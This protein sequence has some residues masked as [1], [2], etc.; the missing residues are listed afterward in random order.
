MT[1]KYAPISFVLLFF[2]LTVEVVGQC[3]SNLVPNPSF[4]D[5]TGC[6]SGTSLGAPFNFDVFDN[7]ANW[8]SP[9]GGTSDAMSTCNGKV[10][11]YFFYGGDNQVTHFYQNPVHGDGIAAIYINAPTLQ[12]AEYLQVELTGPLT[13]GVTYQLEFYASLAETSLIG[14]QIGG[15][16]TN[17]A[18]EDYSTGGVLSATPQVTSGIITDK[19]NWTLVSGSFT[20]T[21][22]ERFLTLGSFTGNAGWTDLGVVTS[23]DTYAAYMLIDQV[24]IFQFNDPIPIAGANQ[25]FC[26]GGSV[27]LDA[28]LSN[29]ISYSWTPSTGLN[30]PNIANPIA[31][32]ASTTTYTVSVDYGGGCIKQDQVTLTQVNCDC[33][34]LNYTDSVIDADC[35]GGLGLLRLAGTDPSPNTSL[36]IEW[37]DAVTGQIVDPNNSSRIQPALA[38]TYNAFIRDEYTGCTQTING[39]VVGEPPLYEVN[40]LN[41][42]PASCAGN[43]GSVEVSVTGGTPMSVNSVQYRI[44]IGSGNYISM[45]SNTITLSNLTP[46]TYL[47]EVL[48]DNNCILN[49]T[50]TITTNCT[51]CSAT[52]EAGPDINLCRGDF[53]TIPVTVS[54]GTPVSVSW[55]PTYALSDPTVLN[56]TFGVNINFGPT[57]YTVTVDFGGGCVYSDYLVI[58][59]KA[60]FCSVSCTDVV[61]AGLDQTINAGDTANL[62]AASSGGSPTYT[63]TASPADPSLAGQENQQSPTVSPTQTTTYMVTADFGGGC[64]ETDDVIITVN[65][66]CTE[67]VDAGTDETINLGNSATITATPSGGTPSYTWTASPADPSLSGQENTQNPTVSPTQTTTYTVTADFG[68]GC[69]DT[70]DVVVT[71]NTPPIFTCLP[72]QTIVSNRSTENW[73]FGNNAGLNFSTS[74][75][76]IVTDGNINVR[77]G[78]TTISDSNGNLLFYTSANSVMNSNHLVMTNGAGISAEDSSTQASTILKAPNNSN[79]YYILQLEEGASVDFTY[80]VVDINLNEV[81]QKNISPAGTNDNYSEKLTAVRHCNGIDYWVILKQMNQPI[82]DVFLLN[83]SG[84]ALSSSQNVSSYS[85]SFSTGIGQLKASPSGRKLAAVSFYGNRL[86]LSDFDNATG[87]IS[88]VVSVDYGTTFEPYGVEFSPDENKVYVSLYTGQQLRAYDI[89]TFTSAAIASSETII[90]NTSLAPGS[91]QLAKDGNIYVVEETAYYIG[92]IDN[93]NSN[94]PTYNTSLL[95]LTGLPNTPRATLGLPNFFPGSVI[96]PPGFNTVVDCRTIDFTLDGIVPVNA[97]GVNWDFGDGS[98]TTGSNVSHTYTSD[99][100]YNVIVS[101]DLDCGGTYCVEQMLMISCSS[102]P[103]TIDAGLDVNINQG[104]TTVFAASSTGGTPSYI[105]TASPT[106]ASLAGQETIQNPSVSP[107]V[108]TTYTVT[109]DFGGGCVDTDDVVVSVSIPCTLQINDMNLLTTNADCGMTNG[110]INGIEVLNTTATETYSW[111]DSNGMQVGTSMDLFNMPTGDYTLTITDGSCSATLGPLT[112]DCNTNQNQDIVIANTMTPNGDGANDTFIILGL[113]NHPN[114]SLKIYNRWGNLVYDKKNYTNQWD[115]TYQGKLLP[116]ATYYYILNLNNSDQKIHKG[117][118]TI[119]R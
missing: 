2:T 62:N 52:V 26:S 40:I 38:G 86:E 44:K 41:I 84:I 79:L 46:G 6:A 63:W 43:D 108:T 68:A 67:T 97:I 77:E 4:E 75:P 5:R 72:G 51:G 18:F 28:S 15:Y 83:S 25:T 7:I 101:Y 35:H 11:S 82:Y 70:D 116:V 110:S 78:T 57:V 117:Y 27:Q 69:V 98:V 12:S 33:S 95:D 64:I 55:S 91:L 30:N 58:N 29:G 22:G 24:A 114:N 10:P 19:D 39:I 47:I 88:N 113:E 36:Y 80:S 45:Y 106:D 107:A 65:L 59:N 56:P 16:L 1:L 31:A 3:A 53:T 66:G 85:G 90:A 17:T 118:I 73:Y 20:A 42:N 50:V 119:L 74:P 109:A 89:S 92:F 71:V 99:G 81:V 49:T 103:E 87:L 14:S 13:A 8:Y 54:G 32:P 112:I 104:E 37:T 111:T 105:W 61:D 93:P 102:C 23:N 96:T 100:T 94:T 48:D 34:L 60:Q 76:T 21:G 115:G 9:T